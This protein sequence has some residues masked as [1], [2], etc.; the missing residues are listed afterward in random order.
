M[1]TKQKKKLLKFIFKYGMKINKQIKKPQGQ[2]QCVRQTYYYDA[3][4]SHSEKYIKIS[5]NFFLSLKKT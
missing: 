5:F 2:C 4:I 1:H 3:K